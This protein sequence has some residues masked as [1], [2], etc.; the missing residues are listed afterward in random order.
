[1]KYLLLCFSL[2]MCFTANAD[3]VGYK[4]EIDYDREL[5]KELKKSEIDYKRLQNYIDNSENGIS[6]EQIDDLYLRVFRGV[7]V[8]GN[9]KEEEFE[10]IQNIIPW[11]YN[12][13]ERF[14]HDVAGVAAFRDDRIDIG[15]CVLSMVSKYKIAGIEF[16][17]VALNVAREYDAENFEN[18]IIQVREEIDK[19]KQ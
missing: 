15:V 18:T 17:D 16:L 13:S 4:K 3:V 14:L 8:N 9:R 1:M 11:Q 19:L 10:K 7:C 2:F 6:D 12:Y 5:A